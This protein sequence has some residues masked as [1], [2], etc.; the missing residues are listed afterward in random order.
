MKAHMQQQQSPTLKVALLALLALLMPVMTWAQ[1]DEAEQEQSKANQAKI[2]LIK[3]IPVPQDPSAIAGSFKM[4]EKRITVT[5]GDFY[6]TQVLINQMEGSQRRMVNSDDTWARIILTAWADALELEAAPSEV[7]KRLQKK[8]PV[9][10]QG[11]LDRW[12]AIGVSPED[13]EAYQKASIKVDHL[14]NLLF[15]SNRTSTQDAFDQFKTQKLQYQFEYAC[16]TDKDFAQRII[17]AGITKEML[18]EFWK[19]DRSAAARYRIPASVSGGIV[20]FNPNDFS[21]EMV[22]S[23]GDASKVTRSQALA[24]FKANKKRLVGSI[25]PNKRHLLTLNPDTPLEEVVSPFSL[26]K[27]QIIKKLTL[28]HLVVE[29]HAAALKAG[30]K[31]NLKEIA[32]T[33][34]LGFHELKDVDRRGAMD[35]LKEF[36]IPAF[37]QLFAAPVGQLSRQLSVVGDMRFFFKV[38]A[39][40]EAHLPELNS[41]IDQVRKFYIETRSSKLAR[42][43]A[44]EILDEM[45]AKVNVLLAPERER[46][47]Q[48][49]DETAEREIARMNI[50]KKRAF[51][52]AR[53]RIRLPLDLKRKEL[54]P[55]IFDKIVKRRKLKLQKTPYFE[56]HMGREDR[57]QI[58]DVD[59][60][61]QMFIASSY[62]VRVLPIGGVTPMILEDHLT[63]SFILGRL[64]DKK[65]PPLDTMGPVD[66]IQATGQVKQINQA[67]F[68][69]RF[70]FAEL[71]KQFDFTVGK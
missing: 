41:V 18:E 3:N 30:P 60:S 68:P 32:K 62:Q 49:A 9:L 44:K 42:E 6:D 57:S 26:V 25:P 21:D 14:K 46:L 27:D 55:A 64:T 1:S 23:L 13:G 66:L 50:T 33:Y 45:N 58:K 39:K 61:R 16:F 20:Y 53:G 19:Q 36:G 71:R 47:E 15:N 12:A 48:E 38:T 2:A 4:G 63:H 11:V 37:S 5:A 29:A 17:D 43:A 52:R 54:L 67:R 51:A 59:A 35:E 7:D 31:V 70:R 24:Y 8:T 56:F 69:R 34:H 40:K 22:A 65:D 10:Y 28:Q